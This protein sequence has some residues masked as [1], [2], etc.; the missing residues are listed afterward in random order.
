MSLF[1]SLP[2]IRKRWLAI[3][4]GKRPIWE[5]DFAQLARL[6]TAS[7]GEADRPRRNEDC[8]SVHEHATREAGDAQ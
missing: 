7:A 3:C 6:L 5:E 1:R 8:G 4:A 2:Q